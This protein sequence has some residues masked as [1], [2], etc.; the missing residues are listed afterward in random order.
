MSTLYVIAY[1]NQNRAHE[2]LSTLRFAQ[3]QFIVQL[4]D[5]VIVTKDANGKI[6][7]DQ[8]V[9]LAASGAIS[10]T[11]WGMLIGLIFFMP[12]LGAVIG[13]LSGFIGG[14]LSDYGIPDKFIKEVGDKLQ[15]SYSELFLLVESATQDKF[16][17][18][19]SRFG[20]E[21]IQTS[22]SEDDTRKLQEALAKGVQH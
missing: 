22:I 20:G 5:A 11:F 6:K 15:P 7:V 10:G 19:L 12:F 14:K 9:N 16:V 4:A 21:V 8:S 13:G 18:E 1:P 3:E 17:A 2:V